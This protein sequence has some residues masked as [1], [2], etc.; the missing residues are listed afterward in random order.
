MTSAAK[1]PPSYFFTLELIFTVLLWSGP[2]LQ[3]YNGHFSAT[4]IFSIMMYLGVVGLIGTGIYGTIKIDPLHIGPFPHFYLSISLVLIFFSLFFISILGIYN[5][6]GI[7][8][9]LLI[10]S[11]LGLLGVAV[12]GMHTSIKS[13]RRKSQ[14]TKQ[15]MMST[16]AG[17]ASLNAQSLPPSEKSLTRTEPVT[18]IGA[19][20]TGLLL[21]L[22]IIIGG[23]TGGVI[24]SY[25]PSVGALL[26]LSI[27]VPIIIL[28]KLPKNTN[29][30]IYIAVMFW[31]S[32]AIPLI[33]GL[34]MYAI[35]R[36]RRLTR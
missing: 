32:A 3:P 21:A 33:G 2:V 17:L 1:R 8:F 6:S 25:I 24:Y 35:V 5:G 10:P 23:I 27:I 11:V 9:Y 28:A 36:A 22:L 7:N 30:A 15:N 19:E 31:C 13:I 4:S 18:Y 34:I 16:G 29:H 26:L 20:K 14:P 12:Y